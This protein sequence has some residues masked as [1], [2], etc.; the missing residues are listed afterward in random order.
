[1]ETKEYSFK[2][3]VMNGFL[4]LF[5]NFAILVLTIAGIV[6]SIIQLDASNG[7]MGGWELGFCGLMISSNKPFEIKY[8][9]TIAKRNDVFIYCF[10]LAS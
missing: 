2:G 7:A 5:V 3:T 9:M 8:G 1:M 4:M 6:H 10:L